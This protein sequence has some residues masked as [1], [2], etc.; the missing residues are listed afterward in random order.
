MN[1]RIFLK[2]FGASVAAALILPS[3][4]L[5]QYAVPEEIPSVLPPFP[6][7]INPDEPSWLHAFMA[8]GVAE[9]ESKFAWVRIYRR[10]NILAQWGLNAFGGRLTYIPHPAE[11]L[12]HAPNFPLTFRAN[13]KEILWTAVFRQE[14]MFQIIGGEGIETAPVIM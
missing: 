4:T 7:R 13:R 6:G 12:V 8:E 2:Y 1:R 10:D 5:Q 3:G 14:N 9:N 11:Q